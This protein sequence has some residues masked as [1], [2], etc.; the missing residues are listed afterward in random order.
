MKSIHALAIDLEDWYHP[1][2][3]RKRVSGDPDGQIEEATQVI[4]NLLALYQV[5]AT[6][7]VV[8]EVAEKFPGLIRKIFEGGH[9]IGSHGF[10]HRP[11]W[12]MDENHFREEMIRFH[13]VIQEVLGDVKIRGFRAP[14]FSLDNGT[15][16]ATKVLTELGYEYDASICP[17]KLNRLYGLRGAPTTP[18]RLSLR[19]LRREDPDSPLFEFPMSVLEWMGLRIPVGGGFY[20]RVI[21]LA[22]LRLSLKKIGQRNSF[23]LYF[24]PWEGYVGTP[25]LKLPLA[26]RFITYYGIGR[27]LKKL[28]V[29]LKE[30]SFTRIDRLLGLEDIS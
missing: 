27:A 30:F 1:E 6:F 2:L 7:F 13:S 26:D 5:V 22:L 23:L 4:L 28:E 17:V 14:T 15:R 3:V 25:Q 8:G 10:S 19:D 9:E 11:L 21:P 20:F 24:H 16:W 12:E 29:F 18:Y